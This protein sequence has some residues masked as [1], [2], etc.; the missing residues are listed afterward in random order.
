MRIILFTDTHFGTRNNSMTWFRSQSSFIYEQ[1]IPYIKQ[2]DDIILIHLGDVFDSR[3]SI[4]PM[5]AHE[6]RKMFAELRTSVNR[7]IVIPGNHD[8]YSE[9]TN[10]YCTP[11]LLLD[12]I[13]I[14][15]IENTT[16]FLPGMIAVPWHDQKNGLPQEGIIFTHT[17][18]TQIWPKNVVFSGHI[19]TP[20]IRG[21]RRN[22][23]SCFPLDFNDTNQD[24]YF[25]EWDSETDK[26]VAIPNKKSIR[27]WTFNDVDDIKVK[28]E[29]YVRI[30][31]QS[32]KLSDP[33]VNAKLQQI[34]KEYKNCTI[35]P[36]REELTKSEIN[37]DWNMTEIIKHN[38]PSQYKK[39]FE[40][41][42]RI[43]EYG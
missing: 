17:D 18:L 12:G 22:L 36:I 37:L 41:V 26:L 40:E 19:H 32:N 2:Y 1:F 7:F 16:E 34:K 13:G 14:D 4:N 30:K 33:D 9:Q 43:V 42:K 27:F 29:D 24:R 10:T 3:S 31:I 8:Y 6:V 28:K 11:K 15:I 23:G 25:Y 38:I 21:N 20:D 39:Q 35:I 5:I